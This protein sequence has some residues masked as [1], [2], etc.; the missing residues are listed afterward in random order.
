MSIE[1]WL[2]FNNGAERLRLP[3]NPESI[4]VSSPFGHSD[5]NIAQ[6]GEY[7]IV[8]ERGL[9][10]YSFTS[11]FPRDYNP[12]YC[13]YNGFPAPWTFVE[14]LERWRDTRRPMRLTIT[15]TPINEAVTIREFTYTPDKA[16]GPGDIYYELRFK[17]FRFIEL[18]KS[19]TVSNAS[20]QKQRPSSPASPPKTYTV[21]KGDSLWKI[22]A[23]PTI[24]GNGAKWP[25]I[26]NANKSVIGK[27]PNL[28]Y[29]GQKLVI[30]NA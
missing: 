2:S 20:T 22:A 18:P 9:K 13:E 10:E 12:V 1:F 25:T 24:Y 3:V 30:P 4:N 5:I 6:L 21:V 17:E 28:I 19:V 23:K 8:G 7:A 27:N 29:P 15:G 16:G 26:Y 14:T 11:F